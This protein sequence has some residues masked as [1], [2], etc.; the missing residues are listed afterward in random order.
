MDMFL[1]CFPRGLT[2]LAFAGNSKVAE[3]CSY[4]D[5]AG[6][7]RQSPCYRKLGQ[8]HSKK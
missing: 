4:S 7:K 2:I 1:T 3:G 5:R 8:H 6:N